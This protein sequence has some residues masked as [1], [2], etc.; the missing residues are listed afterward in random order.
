MSG[1]NHEKQVKQTEHMTKI[2]SSWFT[3]SNKKQ[4]TV[5]TWDQQFIC[6][7]AGEASND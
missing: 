2:K 1:L 6:T 5:Q 7:S 3:V 4:T